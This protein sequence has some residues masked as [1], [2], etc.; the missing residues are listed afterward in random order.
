MRTLVD[1][2]CEARAH[3]DGA[4]SEIH[5]CPMHESAAMLLRVMRQISEVASEFQGPVGIQQIKVWSAKAVKLAEG[6]A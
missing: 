3:R 1:C 4:G 2:G 5:Y 6:N